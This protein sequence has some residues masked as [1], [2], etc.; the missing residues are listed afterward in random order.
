MFAFPG[1]T[2]KLPFHVLN[3]FYGVAAQD[4]DSAVRSLRLFRMLAPSALVVCHGTVHLKQG[5]LSG[6]NLI[7]LVGEL[8]EFKY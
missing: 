6:R 3:V 1:C 8:S 7:I 4:P 2:T 5:R